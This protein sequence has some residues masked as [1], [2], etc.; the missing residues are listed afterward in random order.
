M[1]YNTTVTTYN[2][3]YIVYTYSHPGTLICN[4][5]EKNIIEN[6]VPP[7]YD[8]HSVMMYHRTWGVIDTFW[9][10]FHVT[11]HHLQIHGRTEEGRE[12]GEKGWRRE[13]GREE[14][15]LMGM[16]KYCIYNVCSGYHAASWISIMYIY[17]RHV[18]MSLSCIQLYM[19]WVRIVYTLHKALHKAHT[20]YS[21][22]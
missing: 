17:E 5:L 6:I 3:A 13:R 14:A 21:V 11:L 2:Y 19:C 18:G 20:Y 22:V 1:K 10:V 9:N 12:R 7:L 16:S 8:I 15:V 4:S